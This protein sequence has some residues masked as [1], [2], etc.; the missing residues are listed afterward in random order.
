MMKSVQKNKLFSIV[1]CSILLSVFMGCNPR[2]ERA[3]FALQKAE[4]T[5]FSCPDSALYW[6]QGIQNPKELGEK[7][8]A[9][10]ALLL[11]QAQYRN[12]ISVENDSLLQI[13][14]QYY[15]HSVDSSRKA[16]TCF[17]LAQV[18]R[19]M[20]LKEKALAFFQLADAASSKI[21]DN[22][23]KNLL[24]FHWGR[25]FG[26]AALFSEAISKLETALHYAESLK[27]TS[28][29]I[30]VWRELGWNYIGV[31]E[32]KKARSCLYRGMELVSLKNCLSLSWFYHNIA[33][34]YQYD[35]QFQKALHYINLCLKE[36]T[37]KSESLEIFYSTKGDIFLDLQQY[38]SARYY[39]DKDQ[40]YV[41]YAEKG[42]YH[43]NR[44][45][46]EEAVGNCHEALYHRKKYDLYLD[47]VYQEGIDERMLK[48]QKQYDY[49]S[50][51]HE[52]TELKVEQ[53]RS[54]L[55]ILSISF[56]LAVALL[57]IGVIYI[58][59]YRARKIKEEALCSKESFAKDMEVKLLE[60]TIFLQQMQKEKELLQTNYH[61]QQHE[62]AEEIM[63][64]NEVILKI[65]K[66]SDKRAKEPILNAN[67]LSGEELE[68]MVTVVN[69]CI[70]HFAD[71][72]QAEY[73]KLTMADVHLCCLIRL[74]IPDQNILYLLDIGKIA[75]RKRKSRLKCEKLALREE[76]SLYEFLL[77][78]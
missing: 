50:V 2:K 45:Q 74:D 5:M 71:R 42:V 59:Y 21:E 69:I 55:V 35:K 36:V 31:K 46:L 32:Y 63:Q 3:E 14:Y 40:R 72:L 29:Q 24:Y 52:N 7:L 68:N 28:K 64:N 30:V 62:M 11:T 44:S 34:A 26:E 17:Y 77:A 53:Q 22:Q 54:H 70:N 9:K 4:L 73:S 39:Y 27:D 13:A 41:T 49:M 23:F 19:D 33:M 58:L 66:L 1:W 20:D 43:L 16:W 38:D 37:E 57:L 6:L 61:H 60:N 56:S 78:Y 15:S 18:Y 10:Y 48:L 12:Y 75:L 8:G 67:I 76:E 47:S 25:L 65:K 51:E